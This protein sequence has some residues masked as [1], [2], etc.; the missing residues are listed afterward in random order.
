M[1]AKGSV[2]AAKMNA[3]GWSHFEVCLQSGFPHKK[4]NQTSSHLK[5]QNLRP[6][7]NRGKIQPRMMQ[8]I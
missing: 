8:N 6:G 7:N 2:E 3:D 1:G 4:K 5:S